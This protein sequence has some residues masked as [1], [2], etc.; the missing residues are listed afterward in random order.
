M[1]STCGKPHDRLIIHKQ[2]W[3]VMFHKHYTNLSWRHHG[4]EQ[5][6]RTLFWFLHSIPN[7]KLLKIQ[8]VHNKIEMTDCVISG[9][10]LWNLSCR[11]GHE[12]SKIPLE[13][14]VLWIHT[15]TFFDRGSTPGEVVCL[16]LRLLPS[17]LPC[18]MFFAMSSCLVTYPNRSCFVTSQYHEVICFPNH[19]LYFFQYFIIC[20][21]EQPSKGFHFLK[22][23]IFCCITS[24]LGNVLTI[25]VDWW[26]RALWRTCRD[27]FK[28]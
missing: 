22:T 28:K 23:L 15:R 27:F 21:I 26:L 13:F 8:H 6:Q 18:V 20:N 14:V 11:P 3:R 12:W 25:N 10:C 5:T 19:L 24:V 2:L 9:S 16:S 17:A 4:C 1:H 7:I